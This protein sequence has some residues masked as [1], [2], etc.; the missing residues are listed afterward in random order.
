MMFQASL[1]FD[2]H[3]TEGGLSR[4]AARRGRGALT[5]AQPQQR[6]GSSLTPT[7]LILQNERLYADDLEQ[8]KPA[9]WAALLA[10]EKECWMRPR[11]E[12]DLGR[13]LTQIL[14]MSASGAALIASL[15]GVLVVVVGV[16]P[17]SI[18]SAVIAPALVR[19]FV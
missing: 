12:R 17:A 10:S 4:L 18:A 15:W 16:T 3:Q 13:D 6:L 2:W 1:L 14:A 7:I 19:A 9:N 8:R 11:P 5:C